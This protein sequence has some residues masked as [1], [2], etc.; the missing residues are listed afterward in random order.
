MEPP[1]TQIKHFA[2][3]MMLMLTKKRILRPRQSVNIRSLVK[4]SAIAFCLSSHSLA[5]SF[6]L[7]ETTHN[8][9]KS[10]SSFHVPTTFKSSP[11]LV[12]RGGS[13]NILKMSTSIE[14]DAK[15]APILSPGEKLAAL[16]SKMEELNLDAYIVPSD[17]P[18]LSEYVHAAYMRRGFI[19]GFSGSAGTA[20]VFKDKALL[21]TDSRCV[22]DNETCEC[23]PLFYEIRTCSLF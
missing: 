17:D 20:I 21:W 3:V 9:P 8:Q 11:F 13:T 7:A 18:H 16:R 4:Y 6:S 23:F 5:S 2:F 14:A 15:V 1:R 10:L 12:H 22:Q 19:S